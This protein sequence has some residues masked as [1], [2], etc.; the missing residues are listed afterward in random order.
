MATVGPKRKAVKPELVEKVSST[1]VIAKVVTHVRISTAVAG[2]KSLSN[3]W[4]KISTRPWKLG[5]L[6]KDTKCCLCRR[7]LY[8]YENAWREASRNQNPD[9][10]SARVCTMCWP[11]DDAPDPIFIID[12]NEVIEIAIGLN[13]DAPN[14]RLVT[15]RTTMKALIRRLQKELKK[16]DVQP[17]RKSA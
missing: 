3:F 15:T 14:S 2:K 13:R 5:S 1:Q 7:K 17:T 8:A 4:E 11:A 12:R 9:Y 6:I 16:N 10:R